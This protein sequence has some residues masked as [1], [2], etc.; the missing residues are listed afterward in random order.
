MVIDLPTAISCPFLVVSHDSIR[1][2]VRPS[3]GR[4][5][6]LLSADRDKTASG[7]CRVYELVLSI[8]RCVHASLPE[9]LSVHPSVHRS[10]GP[11]V[12]RFFFN[13][14]IMGENGRK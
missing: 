8:F 13:E 12:M 2:C 10:A 7:F 11:S 1:G 3:V 14:P 6:T 4:S 5:V 9:G